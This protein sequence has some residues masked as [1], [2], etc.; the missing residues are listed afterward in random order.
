M[1]KSDDTEARATYL[2]DPARVAPGHIMAVIHFVRVTQA[3][4]DELKIENLGAGP[5]T[6]SVIGTD[7][8][9][10]MPSADLFES[11]QKV[12]KT[13]AAEILV[14]A[15]NKPF[16]VAFEKQDGTER[17]LRGRL[18][19]PEPLLGRSMCEDLDI[20][21]KPAKAETGANG[22]AS[23]YRLV[24]HRTIKWLVLDGVRYVVGK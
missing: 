7:L 9:R 13:R 4:R 20:E 8:I 23:R 18:V 17:V 10:A 24:D 5:K 3:R 22:A 21:I 14:T 12:T 15:F 19:Q 2:T 6:F 11:E 16:S 1:K